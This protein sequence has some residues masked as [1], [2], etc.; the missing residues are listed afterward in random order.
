MLD[1]TWTTCE[2]LSAGEHYAD[3]VYAAADLYNT[4]AQDA[5]QQNIL[6]A[7]LYAPIVCPN[8]AD[9]ALT[10]IGGIDGLDSLG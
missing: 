9:D 2:H 3:L 6:A 10:T 5:A 7:V 4:S 8:H 1:A